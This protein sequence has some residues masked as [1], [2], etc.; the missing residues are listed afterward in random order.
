M[1]VIDREPLSRCKSEI[2][3]IA[4]AQWNEVGDRG[5]PPEP[6]WP[7]YEAMEKAGVLFMLVGR[8]QGR[9]VGYM[10]VAVHIQ[11]NSARVRQA[12]ISTY[13]VEPSTKRSFRLRAFFREAMRRARAAGVR[14]VS[15]DTEVR[16]SCG[17]LLEALGFR[18][19]SIN[20]L[21]E[22]GHA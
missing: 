19:R 12:A 20:Y 1:M 7:L 13:W 11:P 9:F 15:V 22:V 17:R 4:V 10:G 14:R 16:C 6:N 21:L 5:T 18:Q 2:D 8:E 3:G